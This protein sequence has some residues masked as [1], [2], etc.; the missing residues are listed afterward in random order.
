[1]ILSTRFLYQIST[2]DK[3]DH[4]DTHEYVLSYH[5]Q[6][7]RLMPSF[8]FHFEGLSNFNP[9]VEELVQIQDVNSRIHD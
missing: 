2:L 9:S 1:M 8:E 5:N 4:L 7:S 6:C 3:H